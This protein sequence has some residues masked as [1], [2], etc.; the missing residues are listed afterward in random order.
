MAGLF[1]QEFVEAAAGDW[2]ATA[3][4]T[5]RPRSVP[6]GLHPRSVAVTAIGLDARFTGDELTFR[7]D[8]FSA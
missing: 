5:V 4:G 1:G 2:W 3:I 8:S 6:E 7:P